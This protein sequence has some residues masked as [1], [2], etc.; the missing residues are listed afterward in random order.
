MI[1]TKIGADVVLGGAGDDTIDAGVGNDLVAGEAG[2]DLIFGNGGDDYLGGMDGDDAVTGGSGADEI[3]GGAGN[4][5]L[6]G[7]VTDR[8]AATNDPTSTPNPDGPDTLNGGIGDDELWL[9]QGDLGTGGDGADL[10]NIDHRGDFD[11]GT[12][13]IADFDRETDALVLHVDSETDPATGLP[14]YPTITQ[15]V[16][17]D[18]AD[19]VILA[20]GV[21]IVILRGI[22][23]EDPVVLTFA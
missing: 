23:A 14:D 9:G 19:R 3:L 8:A 5:T 15:T 11:D 6:S 4:D 18:G 13:Q 2:D 1:E 7:F 21:P 20:D 16:T 12:R 22:G 17:A 10:F